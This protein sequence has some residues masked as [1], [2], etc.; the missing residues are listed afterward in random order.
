M[1]AI[2]MFYGIIIYMYFNDNKQHKLPYVHVKYQDDEVIVVIPEG[3]VLDGSIPKAKMKLLLAWMEIH[4]DEL[5]ADWQLAVAG[6]HPYKI[7]PLR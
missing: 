6:E 1:P 3:D 2:S 7:E 4:R 5:M